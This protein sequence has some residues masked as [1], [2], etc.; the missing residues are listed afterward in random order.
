MGYK[1]ECKECS[2][3]FYPRWYVKEGKSLFKE[4]CPECSSTELKKIELD[5]ETLLKE[6]NES[7]K[8]HECGG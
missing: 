8:K 7:L 5:Q 4:K 1:Y 6:L 2:K 3:E